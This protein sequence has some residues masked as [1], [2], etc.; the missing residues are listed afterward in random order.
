VAGIAVAVIAIVLINLFL[1]TALREL[2]AR[3][4]SDYPAFWREFVRSITLGSSV[5]IGIAAFYLDFVQ[6]LVLAVLLAMLIPTL[7]QG[8]FEAPFFTLAGFMGLQL[9][10]YVAT[11]LAGFRFIP[12]LL[13][14]LSLPSEMADWLLLAGMVGVL[15]GI[16]EGMIWLAWRQLAAQ[17]NVSLAEFATITHPALKGEAA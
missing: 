10:A 3:L 11:L 1:L 9:C 14:K 12:P 7:T 6:S 8:R 2:P 13:S 17:L 5:F 15:F 16:R 4:P